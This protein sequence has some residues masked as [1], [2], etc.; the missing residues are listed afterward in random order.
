MTL[1]VV[2]LWSLPDSAL[3]NQQPMP[4]DTDRIATGAVAT[5]QQGSFGTPQDSAF[6]ETGGD[7][8]I[9]IMR[10][11]QSL[12]MAP[13]GDRSFSEASTKDQQ[14]AR[15]SPPPPQNTHH[16]CIFTLFTL[17]GN[18]MFWFEMFGYLFIEQLLDNLESHKRIH[19]YSSWF[20]GNGDGEGKCPRAAAGNLLPRIKASPSFTVSKQSQTPSHAIPFGSLPFPS[21]PQRQLPS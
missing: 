9:Y 14:Q 3:Q 10:W 13:V 16:Q 6:H 5:D 17:H 8:R 15:P 11:L 4:W 12:F 2:F 18:W 7:D 21:R 1:I 19:K 20:A